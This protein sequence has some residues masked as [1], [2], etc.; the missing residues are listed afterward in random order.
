MPSANFIEIESD[1]CFGAD[2]Q[3]DH[4][5]PVLRRLILLMQ[6]S[7][8]RG[9]RRLSFRLMT[10]KYLSLGVMVVTPLNSSLLICCIGAR[11]PSRSRPTVFTASKETH[12]GTG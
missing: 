5:I 7:V 9:V 6:G 10:D 2:L 12:A 1:P 11:K 4:S 8:R 3:L